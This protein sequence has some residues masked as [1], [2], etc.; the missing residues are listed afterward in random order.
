M[1][2][3]IREM[4]KEKN[5]AILIT[6]L[7]YDL[8]KNINSLLD[9]ITNIFNLQFGTAIKKIMAILEDSE[10]LNSNKFITES[11]NK[12]KLESY[13]KVE[14]LLKDKKNILEKEIDNLEFEEEVLSEYNDIVFK[15]TKEFKDNLKEYS[16]EN[17]QK[18]GIELLNNFVLERVDKAK[19]EL[20]INRITDYLS[21]RLYGKLETKIHM[22]IML[23]DNNLI[24]KA[25][26][27]YLRFQEI[28]FKT[29]K[30]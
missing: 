18:E 12:M 30:N 7:K 2:K 10:I 23:R 15:T 9:T 1:D 8:D 25:K 29:I 16:I 6:N 26:E 20:T 4:F 13:Q 3:D 17:I 21:N 11:I 5:R 28:T 27:S 19:E 14:E 24:N 22:E